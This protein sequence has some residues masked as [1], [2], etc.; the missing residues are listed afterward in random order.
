MEIF[1]VILFLIFVAIVFSN[2]IS[3]FRGHGTWTKAF[4]QIATRYGG[5][6]SAARVTRPPAATFTYKTAQVR[7]R[8]K[9]RKREGG[10]PETEFRIAWPNRG[11]RLE[12]MS[13]MQ[14]PSAR[15]L[16][17]LPAIPAGD[18]NFDGDWKVFCTGKQKEEIQQLISSGVRWQIAQLGNFL[19]P[20]AVRISIEKGWLIVR[21]KCFIKQPQA[22]D[23]Y[24]RFCLELY[25]QLMLTMTEG[26]EFQDNLVMSAVDEVRCPICSSD[27]E[28]KMVICIRCKT[29]HCLDCWQ[30]NV[31]C[32]MYACD[33]TRYAIVGGE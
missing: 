18:V 10:A 23:D 33:E 1:P 16:R 12:I 6:F 13:A 14:N 27:I 9:R 5:W 25:D 24:V 2:V 22:L 21:K 7:V 28:G 29:P 11:L 15:W 17:N 26:I 8:C 32:G 31:K 19:A 30:Y 20:A 3:F 4:E